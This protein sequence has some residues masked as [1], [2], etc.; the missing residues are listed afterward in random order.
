MDRNLEMMFRE[1]EKGQVFK[2][3]LLWKLFGLLLWEGLGTETGNRDERVGCDQGLREKTI[4]L[5]CDIS[6][7]SLDTS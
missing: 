5:F 2:G 6:Y 7:R 4:L 3:F 1:A